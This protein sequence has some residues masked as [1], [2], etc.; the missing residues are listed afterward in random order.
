M[1]IRDLMSVSKKQHA[2]TRLAVPLIIGLF[3]LIIPWTVANELPKQL[4]VNTTDTPVADVSADLFD[5]SNPPALPNPPPASPSQNVTINLINRLVQRGVL[6]QADAAELIKQAEEDAATAKAQAESAHEPAA[7]DDAVHVTYVPETVR[8]QIRDELKQDVLA[9]A[10]D[11]NWAAPRTLPEWVSRYKFFGDVRMRYEGDYYPDGNDNTGAFPN[12][13]AINTGSPFDISGTQFSPQYNVDQERQRLR[14]RAR[15]GAEV[16]LGDDF[17][18]GF[19]IVTGENNSPV[20]TN[21]SMGL[22]SQGQGGNF[23]KYALWL[24]RAFIKYELGDVP[25]KNLKLTFGRFDN[26]FFSTDVIWDDDLGFD[27]LALQARYEV[28]EGVTPFLNGG[29][30]PVFNTDL[31]FSSNQPTKFESDDKWLFGAQAGV[32][33]KIKDDINAKF[34]VAIYNFENING[35][36]STPYTPLTPQDAGDTDN[37]RPSFA[38]KGNTY[39]ALRD[40]IPSALNNFGTS[41]QYQYFGLASPYQNLVYT[42]RIDLNHYEPCQVSI[43]GEYVKNLAFDH[44]DINSKA[45]NNRGPNTELGVGDF[46]GG[47]EAWMLNL[48]LGKSAFEKRGDWNAFVGYRYIESDA[49]VDGFNDSDFGGGGTNMK[50]YT[51]GTSLALS[52][53]VRIGLRWMSATQIAGPPLKSDVF[54]FDLNAKF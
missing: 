19:R 43:I 38:Q 44:A 37:S 30:F 8:A 35:R 49:V 46:D 50:G 25:N 16:D 22:A 34:A 12:F 26:P 28:H 32:D 53:K 47:D 27:G 6:T 10:R 5:S 52:P 23:S 54:Q 31:N 13:N 48:Q 20:T 51:I 18:S 14:L 24:D 45:V 41:Y 21:Q 11:E 17:T 3:V 9:Q 39:M 4:A 2:A 33:W 1:I 7:S 36:L 40:I 15:F 29:F 42:G